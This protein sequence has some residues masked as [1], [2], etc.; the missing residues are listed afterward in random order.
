MVSKPTRQRK[1]KVTLVFHRKDRGLAKAYPSP[2]CRSGSG[3]PQLAS[4]G[5]NCRRIEGTEM[6]A[7]RNC[8]A[9]LP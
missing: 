1:G 8:Q 9:T 2:T 4:M 5:K 3:T 7:E 6:L